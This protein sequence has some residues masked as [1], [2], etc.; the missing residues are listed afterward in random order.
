MFCPGCAFTNL[1]NKGILS[2][3]F[4]PARVAKRSSVVLKM[5][6][7]AKR[8]KVVRV[9]VKLYNMNSAHSRTLT[10]QSAERDRDVASGKVSQIE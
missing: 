5:S 10:A 7:T 1:D 4:D 3:H 8:R 9:F 6:A 2:L